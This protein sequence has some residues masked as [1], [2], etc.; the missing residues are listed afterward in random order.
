VLSNE[1][2]AK[3]N[4]YIIQHGFLSHA[5]SVKHYEAAIFRVFIIVFLFP[6]GIDKFSMQTL[7]P[8]HVSAHTISHELLSSA[9]KPRHTVL[10]YRN[11]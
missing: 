11:V 10:G 8:V 1:W 6:L 3:P 4:N 2:K 7:L 9:G 5:V